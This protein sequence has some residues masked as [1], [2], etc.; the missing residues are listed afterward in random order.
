MTAL[1][2]RPELNVNLV[3]KDGSTAL[4]LAVRG[5]HNAM[6]TALLGRPELNVN[7][8]DRDGNT[9]LILAAR[10]GHNAM[11]TALLGRPELDVNVAIKDGGTALTYAASLSNDK[12]VATIPMCKGLLIKDPRAVA[13]DAWARYLATQSEGQTTVMW[14][15]GL[16]DLELVE[17]VLKLPGA[18]PS[19]RR[20][21][22]KSARDMS[23]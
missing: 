4:I 16:N 6:V 21:D 11:V 10:G 15:V 19:A 14:A 17:M 9:A 12:A 2:S 7:L 3:N 8:V 1:L 18:D 13:C 20:K 22:G 23:M 5:G